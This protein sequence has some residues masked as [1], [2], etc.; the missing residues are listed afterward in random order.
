MSYKENL[1]YEHSP[2]FERFRKALTGGK[3]DRVPPCEG[4]VDMQIKEA[5]LGKPIGTLSDDIEFWYRAGYDFYITHINGHV[6]PDRRIDGRFIERYGKSGTE[7]WVSGGSWIT[8]WEEYKDYPWEPV[9]EIDY[10]AV[11]NSSEILPPGMKL[12]VNL[13]PLFCGVWRIMG[14]DEFSY[15]MVENIKLIEGIT[16]RIAGVLLFIAEKV[17]V[18]PHVQGIW[19]GDDLAFAEGLMVS[20]DFYRKYIFPWYKRIGNL[21]RSHNKLYIHHSDGKLDDVIEDLIGCGFHA[22]QPFEPKAMNIY[23][24][25][26]NMETESLSLVM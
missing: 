7:G 21:C 14:I 6:P 9:E 18:Y 4:G 12:I 5:F 26:K 2:D 11:E 24:I 23:D 16:N 8:N 25:K 10:S 17:I 20:P 3:P 15:A 22:L 19:I 1:I 13:G